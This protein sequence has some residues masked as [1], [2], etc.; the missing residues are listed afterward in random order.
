MKHFHFP[1]GRV[2]GIT[3][4]CLLGMLPLIFFKSENKKDKEKKTNENQ[5]AATAEPPEK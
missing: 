1:Q 5:E 4:G 2:L 3:V